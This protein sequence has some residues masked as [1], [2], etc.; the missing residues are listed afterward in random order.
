[1]ICWSGLLACAQAADY[2][3]SDNLVARLNLPSMQ[4]AVQHKVDI[5]AQAICGL[6]QLVPD[7]EK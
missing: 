6:L 7:P 1:M 2:L 3:H 5:Y 4:W